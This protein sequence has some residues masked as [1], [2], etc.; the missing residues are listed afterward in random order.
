MTNGY[1]AS[2]SGQL[3]YSVLT[4]TELP[5]GVDPA[6]KEDYLRFCQHET[7]LCTDD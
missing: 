3:A 4:G 5:E 6:R 7:A 1:G 2:Y